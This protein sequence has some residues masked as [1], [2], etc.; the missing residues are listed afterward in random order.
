MPRLEV[1]EPLV[2]VRL[3]LSALYLR[4][5]EVEA[6]QPELE[7]RPKCPISIETL[8]CLVSIPYH[9]CVQS[10]IIYPRIQALWYHLA[11]DSCAP[12]HVRIS[13]TLT[14]TLTFLRPPL[15]PGPSLSSSGRFR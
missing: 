12:P 5:E 15:H 1:L 10:T 4:P 2:R 3:L 8:A 13:D 11:I 14:C 9:V 6:I 7:V